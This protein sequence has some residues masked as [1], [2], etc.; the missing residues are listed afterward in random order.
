MCSRWPKD[1]G[2]L[3]SLDEGGG[4]GKCRLMPPGWACVT[5]GAESPEA[6]RDP[7]LGESI[8]GCGR[9]AAHHSPALGGNGAETQTPA[10]DFTRPG[11]GITPD[12]DLRQLTRAEH[13][14]LVCISGRWP[15]SS[16]LRTSELIC[17]HLVT[18]S[19]AVKDSTCICRVSA[20]CQAQ[21]M[22]HRPWC[23]EYTVWT[24]W[25]RLQLRG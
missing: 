18:D 6:R 9:S 15:V 20:L 25:P 22:S 13:F 14:I 10:E 2:G 4:L 8:Q 24:N 7:Y 11:P 12:P 1:R 19:S 17:T 3:V 5:S 21:W 16:P 23:Q